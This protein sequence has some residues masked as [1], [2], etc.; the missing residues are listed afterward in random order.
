MKIR[1]FIDTQVFIALPKI[2]INKEENSGS[3]QCDKAQSAQGTLNAR[4]NW[5][6]SHN[7]PR[8]KFPDSTSMDTKCV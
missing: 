3:R 5:Q 7:H 2:I 1:I 4:K 8:T 6:G